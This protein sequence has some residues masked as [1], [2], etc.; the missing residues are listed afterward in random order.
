MNRR[1]ALKALG[2]FAAGVLTLE[3]LAK[4]LPIKETYSLDDIKTT[5]TVLTKTEKVVTGIMTITIPA[6]LWVKQK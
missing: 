5:W 2:V 3:V 1:Q 6:H 4:A